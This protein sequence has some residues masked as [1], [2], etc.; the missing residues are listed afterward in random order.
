MQISQTRPAA[1]TEAPPMRGGWWLL[2]S[3]LSG[4]AIWGMI[5]VA[6]VG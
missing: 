3:V 4:A 5:I 2:P 1:R 6:L